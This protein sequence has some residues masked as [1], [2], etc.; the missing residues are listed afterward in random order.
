MT[1]TPTI[2]ERYVAVLKTQYTKVNVLEQ[3]PIETTPEYKAAYKAFRK[4]LGVPVGVSVEVDAKQLTHTRPGF[5]I[6]GIELAVIYNSGKRFAEQPAATRLE[7][8]TAK[9]TSAKANK[10]HELEL[11]NTM[12]DAPRINKF[13]AFVRAKFDKLSAAESMT[14][15]KFKATVLEFA[16]TLRTHTCP[17]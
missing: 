3:K 12:Q 13:K 2:G 10:C 17:L 14:D 4:W 11:L 16:H 8:L 6:N 9:Y 5:S 7:K 15:T 1:T